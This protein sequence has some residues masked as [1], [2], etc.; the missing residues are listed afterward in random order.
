MTGTSKGEQGYMTLH[1]HTN[2]YIAPPP[3]GI[4][5]EFSFSVCR[6]G[7]GLISLAEDTVDSNCH[8]L[9]VME[10]AVVLVVL[11]V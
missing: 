7:Q 3:A 10:V 11:V 6:D 4:R 5:P 9:E 2:C 1:N 8:D